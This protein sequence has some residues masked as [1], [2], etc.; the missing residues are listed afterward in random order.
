MMKKYTAL[1]LIYITTAHTMFLGFTTID[2]ALDYATYYPEYVRPAMAHTMY[3]HYD[4]LHHKIAETWWG[5]AL[6][7]TGIQHK[8]IITRE[9]FISALETITTERELLGF[10]KKFAVKINFITP[11]I[12]IYAWGPIFGQFH[13]LTMCLDDLRKKNIISNDLII[14]QPNTYLIFDGNVINGSPYNLETL[15]LVFQI[16][17]KNPNT[18]FY[19]SGNYEAEN[20]W[21]NFNLKQELNTRLTPYFYHMQSVEQLFNRFLATLPLAIYTQLICHPQEFV[22]F[23]YFNRQYPLINEKY[24]HGLFDI[25]YDNKISICKFEDQQ[26]S[27]DAPSALIKAVIAAEDRMSDYK[28]HAGLIQREPYLESTVWTLF[29]APTYKYRNYFNFNNDAYAHIVIHQQVAQSTISLYAQD[30]R[31]RTGFKKIKDFNLIT[32][33]NLD[34]TTKLE[35]AKPIYVGCTLDLS[36]SLAQQGQMLKRGILL[37]I[38]QVNAAGGVKGRPIQMI[39]MDDEYTPEKARANIE[40]FI[41]K[42]NGFITLSS[43]G[44]LTLAAYLDMVKTGSLYAFFPSTGSNASRDATIK[45]IINWRASYENETFALVNYI[46]TTYRPEKFAVIYQQDIG[47]DLIPG[48]LKA[49]DNNEQRLVKIPYERSTLDVAPMI[50]AIEK[51][52]A[53][54]IGFFSTMPIALEFLRKAPKNLILNKH[55]FGISFIAE[56]LFFKTITQQGIQFAITQPTPP[57]SI[58]WKLIQEYR[59]LL[60]TINEESTP[61]TIE[62]FISASLMVETLKKI[63][64]EITA[65]SINNALEKFKNYNYNGMELNFDPNKRSITHYLWINL[66]QDKWLTIQNN[67]NGAK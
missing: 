64:G 11:T 3:T 6:R 46:N 54:A 21:L 60:S 16:M 63:D 27:T 33:Q 29:S 49:L 66:G 2:E 13:S 41:K 19:L 47:S 4:P 59:E 57:Y 67:K 52:Q 31:D 5:K 12:N 62:G 20:L 44:S 48:A 43:V 17:R 9:N 14:Q 25:T 10:N 34:T 55:L 42:Y 23:S 30:V 35:Q 40:T 8:Q 18:A 50:D 22:R 56:E 61:F 26:A 32:G 39:F 24:C 45:N 7:I 36:R 1:L 51:S 37:R 38:N 28:L 53:S 58:D 15:L 65:E